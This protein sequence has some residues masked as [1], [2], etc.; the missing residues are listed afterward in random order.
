M[1]NELGAGNAEGAK[2]AVFTSVLLVAMV[3]SVLAIACK[4]A[5]SQVVGVLTNNK[6]VEALTI[7]T[8]PILLPTFVCEC[9]AVWGLPKGWVRQGKA[10]LLWG[11]MQLDTGSI[12]HNILEVFWKVLNLDAGAWQG[13]GR[14]MMRKQWEWRVMRTAFLAGVQQQ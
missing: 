9:C 7:L 6:E 11:L 5:D 8:L 2:L 13:T 12:L 3:Q 10:G 1:G 14:R 4:L